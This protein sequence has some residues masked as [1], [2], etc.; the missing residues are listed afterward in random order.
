MRRPLS[1]ALAG[2][3]AAVWL[4]I[5]WM[6]WKPPDYEPF[7]G[8]QICLTGTVSTVEPKLQGDDV[9][10]RMILSDVKVEG[11]AGKGEGRPEEA[12][13]SPL[14][15]DTRTRLSDNSAKTSEDVEKG[16]LKNA[17]K[18]SEEKPKGSLS[19]GKKDRVLCVLE[20]EPALSASARVRVSGTLA[21]FRRAMNEGEFDVRLY[22]HILRI[23]F[24]IRD[25][26]IT[27]AS[28]PA[29]PLAASLFQF[30]KFITAVIDRVFSIQNAPVLKAMLTGEKG[31][32]DEETKELYQGAGVMHILSISGLHL[33]LIG[34]GLFSLLARAGAPMPAR[35]ASSILAVALYGKM[36]GMGTSAF[37]ALVMLSLFIL[38]RVI[39]RTYDH[40]T[41]AAIAS[42]LLLIDQPLYL[43]HTG[44]LFS[45]SAIL[46]MGILVPA[47]PGKPLK[48]LA[49]PL[50]TLP[51]YLWTYGT[52]PLWSLII[53]LLVIPLMAVVMASG[54]LAVAIG[55]GAMRLSAIL[56][57]GVCRASILNG[58]LRPMMGDV[59]QRAGVFEKAGILLARIAGL[60]A[61][62]ILRLYDLL[63]R[64]TGLLP[65]HELV[66]GRPAPWQI[67]L[68]YGMLLLLAAL[69]AHIQMP[70]VRKRIE[71]GDLIRGDRMDGGP[72]R[73]SMFRLRDNRE[74][75]RFAVFL[76]SLWIA[77]CLFVLTARRPPAFEMDFL[78]V[79]QG[80][81]IFLASGGR[82]I[83]IDGGSS[84]KTELAKYTLLPFLR[85]KGAARLDAVILTHE[86]ID[87]CSG[88]LELLG[89]EGGAFPSWSGGS[90]VT[91][92]TPSSGRAAPPVLSDAHDIPPLLSRFVRPRP[93]IPIG[94]IFLPD[95]APSARGEKYRRIEELASSLDIPISYIAV[96]DRIRF[97][98]LVF[99]CLHPGR[100]ADYGDANESSTVL[101]VKYESFS[102]LLT[103]DIE[104][105][106]EEDLNAVLA[107][108][109]ARDGSVDA[110]Q[111]GNSGLASPLRPGP[112][113]GVPDT[114]Q[115][116]DPPALHVDVLKVAHHGSRNA[117]SGDFLELVSFD[118]AVISAGAGNLY[119]HPH[120]ELLDRIAGRGAPCYRTDEL[121]EV[122]ICFRRGE[123][124]ETSYC[125]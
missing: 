80:D 67:L 82:N 108:M 92:E 125:K 50:G 113:D 93:K 90:H 42:F 99:D 24:S 77:A 100:G 33:S 105:R 39:G 55:G 43:L 38:S 119:G 102:A 18:A 115:E 86:D 81:G 45:F 53:N 122:R 96:G 47:L 35:A 123:L 84:S 41:A 60:P 54:A 89:D 120:R 68:Y 23:G 7:R 26:T 66:A 20:R 6:P 63:A 31:L 17:G 72:V 34:I 49:I 103:G 30:R 88:I 95:I 79:G 36:T 87:H 40:L 114:A 57:E 8:S 59:P 73:H 51:V 117:T 1:A 62:L 16:F 25:T 111:G 32:L 15:A 121:G 58:A 61:E 64:V 29:D 75:R 44:F 46:S 52:F 110:A 4:A 109:G 83:L 124:E 65:G 76:S 94:R 116:E 11:V 78:Y 101:L 118:A 37:R 21:P 2:F 10:W 104:G 85:C 97:G 22:Y 14:S 107:G 9:V 28:T 91:R 12:A 48:A 27:A 112:Q 13:V 56:T 70:S 5:M 71:Q 74:R 98:G 19:L 69:S 106:G 3:A